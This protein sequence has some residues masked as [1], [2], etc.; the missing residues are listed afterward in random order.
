MLP[1]E[2][3]TLHTDG[4]AVPVY[5]RAN[6]PQTRPSDHLLSDWLYCEERCCRKHQSKRVDLKRTAANI[7]KSSAPPCTSHI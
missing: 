5:F 1:S 3:W 7:R 4:S 2:T 6:I